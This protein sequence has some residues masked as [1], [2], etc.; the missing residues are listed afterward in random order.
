MN[1]INAGQLTT[2]STSCP[3]VLTTFDDQ[4]STAIT[5]T[6]ATG[7]YKPTAGQL[8]SSFNNKSPFGSW[9]LRMTDNTAS[10]GVILFGF[11]ITIGT[12]PDITN[13][14]GNDIGI[15]YIEQS[16]TPVIDIVT[17][18]PNHTE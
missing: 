8:L 14:S 12:N 6:Y 17:S 18:D 7:T 15:S 4:A 1:L 13:N 3:Q 5:T 10:D 16:S 11:T 9:K 2:P